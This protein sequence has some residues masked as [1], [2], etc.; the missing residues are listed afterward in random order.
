MP[1]LY[2]EKQIVWDVLLYGGMYCSSPQIQNTVCSHMPLHVF[3][4]VGIRN[5]AVFITSV[6][7]HVMVYIMIQWNCV[8]FKII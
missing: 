4:I 5:L 1:L 2:R 6:N 7:G 3:G 8:I